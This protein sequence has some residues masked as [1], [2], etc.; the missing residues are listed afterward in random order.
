LSLPPGTA[1]AEPS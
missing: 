1:T